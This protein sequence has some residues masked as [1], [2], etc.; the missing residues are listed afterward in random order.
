MI[1]LLWFLLI[2]VLI[3]IT[4]FMI[5]IAEEKI[6]VHN[7]SNALKSDLKELDEIEQLESEA[8]YVK[9]AREHFDN[10]EN[11]RECQ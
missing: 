8:E 2:L 1:V 3:G 7:I 10:P 9:R 4:A 5:A 6:V 11:L